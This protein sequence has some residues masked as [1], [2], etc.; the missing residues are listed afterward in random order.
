MIGKVVVRN[1]V[2][3]IIAMGDI[4]RSGIRAIQSGNHQIPL[5]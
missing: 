5:R 2:V 1:G 4:P 3:E